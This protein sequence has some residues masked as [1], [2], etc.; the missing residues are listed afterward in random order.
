MFQPM[1]WHCILL[2]SYLK[3]QEIWL[4]EKEVMVGEF[5]TQKHLTALGRKDIPVCGVLS[6]WLYIISSARDLKVIEMCL[7]HNMGWI[8]CLNLFY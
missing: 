4:L 3:G 5:Q 7:L 1:P 6:D 8:F 2:S